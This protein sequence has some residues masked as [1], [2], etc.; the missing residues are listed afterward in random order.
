MQDSTKYEKILQEFK[1]L[2]KKK[3]LQKVLK[4]N[5][6]KEKLKT[7]T[8]REEKLKDCV[9]L[10]EEKAVLLISVIS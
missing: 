8:K 4:I 2:N 9:L 10:Y 7:D 1:S 3:N 5:D 6:E